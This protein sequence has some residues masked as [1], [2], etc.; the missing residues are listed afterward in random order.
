MGDKEMQGGYKWDDFKSQPF[1]QP[2]WLESIL[3]YMSAGVSPSEL[4]GAHEGI[5]RLIENADP[6]AKIARLSREQTGRHIFDLYR[7]L[8]P[9]STIRIEGAGVDRFHKLPGIDDTGVAT[10]S[11]IEQLLKNYPNRPG[12]DKQDAAF[13]LAAARNNPYQP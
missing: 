12:M 10:Y 7:V 13:S 2:G 4:R 8:N 6:N 3:N 9:D 5:D 1:K 11:L